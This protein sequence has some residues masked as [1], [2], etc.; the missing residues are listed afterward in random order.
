M[1]YENT[2]KAH[3]GFNAAEIGKQVGLSERQIK[4]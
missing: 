1:K 3:R 2:F 4:T